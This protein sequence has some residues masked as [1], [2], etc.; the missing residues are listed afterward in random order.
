MIQV[1]LNGSRLK[2]DH[3]DIPITTEQL[4]TSAKESVTVGAEA[5]H[6]HVRD[7]AGKETLDFQYVS[8]QVS[9]IKTALPGIPVGISTGEWIEPDLSKR[10]F[11]IRTW[12]ILPD[13]ASVNGQEAGFEMVADE[14]LKKGVGIE[15]GINSLQAAVNFRNSGLL[16]YCFRI[17]LEP[18]EQELQKALKNLEAI[19]NFLS[20]LLDKQSVLLHGYDK[21]CWEL[22]KIAHQKGYDC[23][24]G[25]EDVLTLPTGKLASSNLEL[26][27]EASAILVK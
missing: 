16:K 2:I 5:I 17:L 23:R 14:L 18:G 19:E 13:F 15:A 26:V 7:P 24:V 22:L 12:V 11:L 8:E 20:G 27:Q 10:I 4:C 6:F 9:G 1:A 21:T 25:F 3:P